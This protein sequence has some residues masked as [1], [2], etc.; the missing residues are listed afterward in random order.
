MKK[1]ATIAAY[2]LLTAACADAPIEPRAWEFD[3]PPGLPTHVYPPISA[4]QRADSRIELVEDLVI[5]SDDDPNA[6]F[7]YISSVTV[8]PAGRIYVPDP[9]N[10][11]VQ[12]FGIDGNFLASVGGEGEGPGEMD[13][14]RTAVATKDHLY[15]ASSG[16]ITVWST[17]S[18][19]LVDEIKPTARIFG[20]LGLRSTEFLVATGG[21]FEVGDDG[22]PRQRS[23]TS[24]LDLAGESTPIVSF[25]LSNEP[26]ARFP[27]GGEMH[28][29]IS[30]RARPQVAVSQS[31][32]VYYSLSNES[33][34]MAL[35]DR[36]APL[37]AAQVAEAPREFNDTA[38]R[39]WAD[40]LLQ[41]APNIGDQ[42]E[43]NPPPRLAAVAELRVDGH[44]RLHVYGFTPPWDDDGRGRD[45]DIYNASGARVL[46][47]RAPRHSWSVGLG[48]FVYGVGTDPVT[49]EYRVY[50]WR[51][52]LPGERNDRDS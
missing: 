7:G 42:L 32:A 20:V 6:L 9:T 38:V 5:G 11:R 4:E 29:A 33:Q 26:D 37:W 39:S 30:P 18:F 47:G 48:D 28:L 36:D 40:L 16:K 27:G 23:V 3:V 45:V 25:D 21:E 24:L 31:G 8:D 41:T 43:P 14:P 51:L 12:I 10:H 50:R 46:S 1:L 52:V 15:V 35:S 2:S 44:D 22:L 17:E 34:I 19:E 13:G 49:E